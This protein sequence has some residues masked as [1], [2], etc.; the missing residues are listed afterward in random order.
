MSDA[1]R[2]IAFVAPSGFLPD[3]QAID[4]SARYFTERGWRVQAGDAC[5]ERHLRFAGPDALRATELQRFAADRSV[6]VVMAARG[7]Y[8]LT[9]IL[10]RLDFAAIRRAERFIVGYSDFTAFNLAY[11]AQT[12]G[13]SWQGPSSL[14]FAG[15]APDEFTTGRFF[16]VISGGPQTLRFASPA[17]A[18]VEVRG[19]LWGGNL[20]LVCAL[21]GTPN[22]PR[23]RGG[24]LF[25][26]DVNE[27][28][29]CIER[30]LL[31]LAQAGVLE[32]QKAVILGE[33]N[34]VPVQHN[35]NGFDLAHVIEHLREV[36]GVPVV[37]GLPFGHVPRKATLPVGATAR[38]ACAGGQAHLEFPG[39]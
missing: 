6:D 7:G 19:L 4:R 39:A 27:P 23:V 33:F 32:R 9:R 22:F 17:A 30:M 13:V 14:V 15:D 18:D 2:V 24:I 8:G 12:G 38:L 21:L 28:A 35:D 29:Y 1:P 5:F 11:L 20:A 25:L 16:D 36:C 34:P 10:E 26:E 3:V 31:Q 37:T